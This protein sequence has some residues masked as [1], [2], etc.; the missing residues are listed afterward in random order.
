QAI[1]EDLIRHLESPVPIAHLPSAHRETVLAGCYFALGVTLS[2]RESPRVLEIADKL[3]RFGPLWVMQADYLRATYYNGV[4]DLTRAT[5]YRQRAEVHAVHLGSSSQVDTWAPA[6]ATKLGLRAFDV[7]TMKQSA[8]EF[9][10]FAREIP[11]LANEERRARGTYLALRGRYREALPLLEVDEVPQAHFGWGR[12]RG[13]LAMVCNALGD[14]QRALAVCEDALSR[15]TPED[16]EFTVLNLGLQIELSMSKLGLGRIDEARSE[17]DALI[18]KH[19]PKQ[20]PLTLGLLH[21]ARFRLAMSERNY[22]DANEHLTK[23]EGW[24]NSTTMPSL[25]EA[26]RNLRRELS[27]AEAPHAGEPGSGSNDTIDASHV[28][29]RAELLLKRETGP[30]RVLAVAREVSGADDGFLLFPDGELLTLGPQPTNEL[31]GWAEHELA[32]AND[33]DAL[34]RTEEIDSELD[35]YKVV[36]GVRYFAS[37]LWREGD[38]QGG[39]VGVLVLGFTGTPRMPERGLLG[40]IATHIEQMERSAKQA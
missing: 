3:E 12:T 17:L 10:R 1:L 4:G 38:S 11:A 30:T 14:H 5:H 25:L 2:G 37:P 24:Y 36:D 29:A 28:M 33:H 7:L 26:A 8:H 9:A 23:L 6:D 34:I 35:P 31:L 16:L 13:V 21:R 32:S 18:A 15:M 27:R 19:A 39:V 40:L 22:A 20:S